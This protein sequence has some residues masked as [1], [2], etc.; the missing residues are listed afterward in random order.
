VQVD[1]QDLRAHYSR[2]SDAALI[3]A[4]EQGREAYIPQAWEVITQEI[5]SRGITV[6]DAKGEA[7]E[8]QP[9]QIAVAM[10]QAGSTPSQVK[11][12]L[13][14]KGMTSPEVDALLT[15][16]FTDWRAAMEK[17]ASKQM[18]IGAAWAVGGLAVTIATYS[19][20][21][22]SGGTY[23]VAWGAVLF[24][25]IRFFRGLALSQRARRQ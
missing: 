3:D 2:F 10:L 17:H 12:Q 16:L 4:Y 24:G 15:P 19:A 20:V 6:A 1:L 13:L 25:T 22:Q 5:E 7:T 14:K 8:E 23:F 18:K 11:T 21:A 9:L